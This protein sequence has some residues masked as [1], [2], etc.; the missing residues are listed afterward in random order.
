M[1]F[2]ISNVHRLLEALQGHLAGPQTQV[3]SSAVA[4]ALFYGYGNQAKPARSRSDSK[5]VTQPDKPSDGV[6]LTPGLVP[7]VKQENQNQ[8]AEA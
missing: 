3:K 1:F 2:I 5:S 6:L 8:Q 7:Y 4:I